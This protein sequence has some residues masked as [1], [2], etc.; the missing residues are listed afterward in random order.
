MTILRRLRAV[1]VRM[2]ALLAVI[3]AGGCL[4]IPHLNQ[5]SPEIT[6]HVI[7]MVT[8]LPIADA[9]VEFVENPSIAVLTDAKGDFRVPPTYKPELFVPITGAPHSLDMFETIKPHLRI[10][11]EGFEPRIVDA[12]D[13]AALD[14]ERHA[15]NARPTVQNE[16]PVYLRTIVLARSVR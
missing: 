9:R 5:R 6:G 7:D 13:P 4:A 12:F 10:T 11:K 1:V 15:S 8:A 3:S 16:A 14:S 2:L